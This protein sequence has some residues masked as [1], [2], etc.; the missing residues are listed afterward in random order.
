MMTVRSNMSDKHESW[1]VN[2][3]LHCHNLWA[4]LKR[5]DHDTDTG[6]CQQGRTWRNEE[7]CAVE[8]PMQVLVHQ[9]GQGDVK[10]PL[11]QRELELGN[12]NAAWKA[13]RACIR[14]AHMSCYPSLGGRTLDCS[15]RH[16]QLSARGFWLTVVTLSQHAAFVDV[17]N[18]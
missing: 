12:V 3:L 16:Q 18:S 2:C 8:I 6:A 9:H 1:R 4:Q 15:P 17:L 5:Y 7:G 14:V 11:L 10:C 13:W